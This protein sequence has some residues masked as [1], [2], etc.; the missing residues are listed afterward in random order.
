MILRLDVLQPPCTTIS[1]AVDN[2]SL[3]Q[4]TEVLE[5][6]VHDNLLSLSVTNKEYY[7]TVN[8]PVDESEDFCATINAE[9]FL[10]LISKITTE[11]VEF[12][13]T[14]KFLVV[15]GNGTYKLP[16][17]FEGDKLMQLPT[18]SIN[19]VLNDF[20]ISTKT[21]LS[22]LNLNSVQLGVG[23]ISNPVQKYYYLD[24]EGALT[25]TSGATVNTFTLPENIKLLLNARLVKLF[26]LFDTDVVRFVYGKDPISEEIDVAKV[27]FSTDTIKLSAVLSCDDTLLSRVPVE[28]IRSLAE[29]EPP[30]S[31]TI[32]RQEVLETLE[33]FSLFTSSSVMSSIT[34]QFDNTSILVSDNQ[35]NS[36]ERIFYDTT[37]YDID[38]PYTTMLD[39]SEFSRILDS[40]KERNIKVSFGNGTAILLMSDSV[41]NIIPE[42][43]NQ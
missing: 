33:R 27:S 40:H 4:L 6:K 20:E 18:I 31:V 38:T 28:K 7:V 2:N 43:K 22:I 23:V 11:T 25:F 42:I 36:T 19:N 9:V 12:S 13:L 29:K 37:N 17:V 3:S 39:L 5:L 1:A 8:I 26:K 14:D 30:Y 10:K 15:K 34:I 41:V 32:S 24:S 21:L 16:L 35:G